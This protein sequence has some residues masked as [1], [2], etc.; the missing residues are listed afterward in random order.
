MKKMEWERVYYKGK[1]QFIAYNTNDSI[2]IES[3]IDMTDDTCKNLWQKITNSFPSACSY[4]SFLQA[5]K[6]AKLEKKLYGR[7][8][9]CA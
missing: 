4:R 6:E 8:E 7:Y 1:Y 2:V 3:G 5:F 9:Q